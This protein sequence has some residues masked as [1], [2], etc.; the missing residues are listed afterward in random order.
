MRTGGPG[1][2]LVLGCLILLVLAG[3]GLIGGLYYAGQHYDRIFAWSLA[4]VHDAVS[5]R[6]PKDLPAEERQRL[7]AAFAAAEKAAGT[8]RSSPGA[9]QR[10]QSLMLE[11][12]H[13]TEGTGTL[14]VQ[15][16]REITATL[17]KIG[18]IGETGRAPR[19]EQSPP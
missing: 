10:L 18:T 4:R 3:I 5:L 15:Q 16:V 14:T 19:E 7:D 6:L 8:A 13:Q 11:L 1:K 9:A 12:A 2:P 17:E